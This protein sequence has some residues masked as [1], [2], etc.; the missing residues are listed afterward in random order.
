MAAALER[1]ERTTA[2]AERRGVQLLLENM[3]WEPERAEVHYLGYSIEECR[4]FFDRITSPALK[5]AFT[6]NHDSGARGHRR[7]S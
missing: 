4:H 7:L 1:I 6:I 2:Q 3:N 5:W